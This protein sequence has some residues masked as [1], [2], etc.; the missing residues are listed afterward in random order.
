MNLGPHIMGLWRES[1]LKDQNI[2]CV[3]N[4]SSEPQV[5]EL[6]NLNLI[7]T[8]K[9]QDLISLQRIEDTDG[10]LTLAP[11]QMAWI[12]NKD[13]RIAPQSQLLE[14]YQRLLPF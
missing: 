4:F 1:L 14:I 5:L 12:A 8:Q 3:F 11:Y 6:G 10:Q 7:M 9:W 2:F 13:G